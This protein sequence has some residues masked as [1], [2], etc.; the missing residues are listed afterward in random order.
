MATAYRLVFAP[1]VSN[2]T[3]LATAHAPAGGITINGKHFPGGEFIPPKYEE[4]AT[5]EQKGKIEKRKDLFDDEPDTVADKPSP[6][7]AEQILTGMIGKVAEANGIK[8]AAEK[9]DKGP[10]AGNISPA[11]KDSPKPEKKMSKLKTAKLVSTKLI[12]EIGLPSASQYTDLAG[13][14]AES[15][16][17]DV[18]AKLAELG[19]LSAS[20]RVENQIIAKDRSIPLPPGMMRDKDTFDGGE[21]AS[22]AYTPEE[23]KRI[24]DLFR[25]IG[26]FEVK[27]TGIGSGDYGPQGYEVKL[28]STNRA[29]GNRNLFGVPLEVGIDLKRAKQIAKE[30]KAKFSGRDKESFHRQA[31]ERQ[32]DQE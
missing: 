25:E 14:P 6:H 11:G 20:K 23:A 12:T 16:A 7:P 2:V 13:L 30:A 5:P 31:V 18:A 8:P 29:A 28:W 19:H 15:L 9:V 17:T 3:T 4:M 26:G 10:I 32:M 1:K 24:A 27:A 22:L 21:Y